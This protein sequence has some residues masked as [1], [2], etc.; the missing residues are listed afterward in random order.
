[1]AKASRGWHNRR[2]KL[3]TFLTKEGAILHAWHIS[4]RRILV[5]KD[6]SSYTKITSITFYIFFGAEIP[7]AEIR[8]QLK[9]SPMILLV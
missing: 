1:M 8:Q 9:I 5:K 2:V 3:Y 7:F 4:M 6:F